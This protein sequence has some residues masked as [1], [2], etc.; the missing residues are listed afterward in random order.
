MR[1]T[2]FLPAKAWHGPGNG[3]LYSTISRPAAPSALLSRAFQPVVKPARAFHDVATPLPRAP[4]PAVPPPSAGLACSRWTPHQAVSQSCPSVRLLHTTRILAEAAQKQDHAPVKRPKSYKDELKEKGVLD[5]EEHEA[6]EDLGF[7]KSEKAAQAAQVNLSAKLSKD[8]SGN[9]PQSGTTKEL[10][11]LIKIA[12]PEL[13]S[14]SFAFVFLLIS[15]AVSI[16]VPFSIGKILDMSTKGKGEGAEGEEAGS[17]G[18]STMFGLDIKTFYLILGGVLATGAAANFG[19]IIILRIVG[20]RIVARLRSNL[21]RKTFIQ[22]AEFFDANR[23]GDLIS[24]LGS[25]TIIVGKSITQNM[26]DGL[27]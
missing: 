24:R 13:G 9:D 17:F 27:R 20:E 2:L 19:R 26:S 15:S 18:D 23:V 14:L 4:R 16:S 1:G 6:D 10:W 7:V 25:D 21:Y 5:V 22:N 8:G 12:R 3:A 11:R